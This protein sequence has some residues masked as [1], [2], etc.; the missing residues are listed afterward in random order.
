MTPSE[1]DNFLDL[2][3]VGKQKPFKFTGYDF[4]TEYIFIERISDNEFIILEDRS[5]TKAGPWKKEQVYKFLSS[6]KLVLLDT[7]V[8]SLKYYKSDNCT[9]GAIYTSEPNFHLY[10]CEKYKKDN[11][12]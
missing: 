3:Y 7:W 10:W 11:N 9:C 12:E 6:D 8:Y 4:T 2:W 1:V 5:S